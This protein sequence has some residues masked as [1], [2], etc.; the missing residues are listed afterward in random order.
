MILTYVILIL[1]YTD[2][3]KKKKKMSQIAMQT[4][5]QQNLKEEIPRREELLMF[6]R[7][8]WPQYSHHL[9][10]NIYRGYFCTNNKLQRLMHTTISH[11][12]QLEVHAHFPI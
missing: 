12:S 6:H 2:K 3:R 10:R 7:H 4:R 8:S 1:T 5:V 11:W 9:S